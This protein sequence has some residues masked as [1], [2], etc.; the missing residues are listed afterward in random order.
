[1]RLYIGDLSCILFYPLAT[2]DSISFISR[3]CPKQ[4]VRVFNNIRQT[5]FIHQVISA[6]TH[7]A[8]GVCDFGSGEDPGAVRV[9]RE[10][11]WDI[12]YIYNLY[13]F[14]T[15]SLHVADN[16]V[17][18]GTRQG[19]LFMYQVNLSNKE[20]PIAVDR[21]IDAAQPVVGPQIELDLKH[22]NKVFSDKPIRQ[23]EVIVE[24]Q[25][26]F[27]L[28]TDG[29]SV[30]D[31]HDHKRAFPLVHRVAATKQASLFA[32]DVKRSRSLTGE[33]VLMVR[34]VVAVK[35]K[36]QLW[37]WKHN[38]FLRLPTPD[39]DLSD[40]PRALQWSD[41]TIVVGMKGDYLYFDVSEIIVCVRL[42]PEKIDLFRVFCSQALRH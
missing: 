21:S 33:L 15:N 12:L 28:T 37:Y 39:I 27:A 10:L 24:H 40:V 20:A 2:D 30:Y 4:V 31:M 26:L 9:H 5:I 18:I 29:V 36:L 25:L 42:S 34:M 19:H 13:R 16:F 38:E 7:H 32:L 6:N 3:D 11:W 23:I 17:I 8:R 1:M 22:Y 41:N 14:N 35:R